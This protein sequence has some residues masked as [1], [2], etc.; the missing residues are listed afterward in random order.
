ML[1]S[2]EVLDP[3]PYVNPN[4]YTMPASQRQ[5]IVCEAKNKGVPKEWK[6]YY[7]HV[8]KIHNPTQPIESMDL[9]FPTY[10]ETAT[11]INKLS[12]DTLIISNS[13]NIGDILAT[14]VILLNSTVQNIF[15]D[16]IFMFY[17]FVK[18]N[19][20]GKNINIVVAP[21]PSGIESWASFDSVGKSVSNF[22]LNDQG[23]VDIVVEAGTISNPELL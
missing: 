2:R 8:L 22:V 4:Y 16:N 21:P 5:A 11:K 20:S 3:R 23:T 18:C 17:S 7:T 15:A 6:F 12:G 13:H 14:N 1:S 9:T 19:V 10:I